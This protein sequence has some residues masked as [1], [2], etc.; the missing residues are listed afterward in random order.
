M[1]SRLTLSTQATD[2]LHARLRRFPAA[3][4]AEVRDVLEQ[5]AEYEYQL[6]F[7]DCPVDTGFMRDHIIVVFDADGLRYELGWTATD[8]GIEAGLPFYPPFVIFGTR[9]MEGRDFLF[10]NH[11]L[12]RRRFQGKLRAALRR[13]GQQ[14]RLKGQT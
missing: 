3:A 2:A 6:V 12:A 13:A 4:L 9:F 5:T 10:P 14:S 11:L 1:A 8:F 7:N